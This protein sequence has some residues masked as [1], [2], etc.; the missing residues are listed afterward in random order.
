MLS[1]YF[2][3]LQAATGHVNFAAGVEEGY[4]QE[5]DVGHI[6]GMI[7]LLCGH[8]GQLAGFCLLFGKWQFICKYCCLLCFCL[9]CLLLCMLM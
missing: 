2:I 7:R 5:W 8:A 9:L 3:L 1:F 4:Q 6:V